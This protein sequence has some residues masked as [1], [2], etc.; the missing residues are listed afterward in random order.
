MVSGE[1]QALR[2]SWLSSFLSNVSSKDLV[3]L[4]KPLGAGEVRQRLLSSSCVPGLELR[5]RS[6][7]LH[8][9]FAALLEPG[10]LAGQRKA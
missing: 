7:G 1:G 6:R 2:R 4:A 8:F 9:P 5:D 3:C 10:S